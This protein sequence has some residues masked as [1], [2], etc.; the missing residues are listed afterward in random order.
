MDTARVL[1]EQGYVA[2]ALTMRGFRGSDGEDDCGARQADDTVE[3]LPLVGTATRRGRQPARSSGF[4]QGGQ[5]AL[6]AAA[7]TTL[8]RAVVAYFPVT[9]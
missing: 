4:G 8:L 7:R 2:L 3:A 9:D 5:V 6:L 1:A